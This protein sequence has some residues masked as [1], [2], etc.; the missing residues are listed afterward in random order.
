MSRMMSA[1]SIS[2]WLIR[3]PVRI[4]HWS[5]SSSSHLSIIATN[6]FLAYFAAHSTKIVYWS[7]VAV[8]LRVD[9]PAIACFFELEKSHA[10]NSARSS[11][12]PHH[13]SRLLLATLFD[14]ERF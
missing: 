3:R 6:F 7:D 10:S 12:V 4:L 5:S 13:Q 1:Y 11:L 8:G 2:V 14:H 9:H